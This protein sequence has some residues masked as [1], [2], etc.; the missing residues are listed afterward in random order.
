MKFFGFSA[1]ARA[2]LA[3]RVGHVKGVCYQQHATD[4][5]GNLYLVT[6]CYR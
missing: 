5:F 6:R 3:T 2:I 1:L 4:V